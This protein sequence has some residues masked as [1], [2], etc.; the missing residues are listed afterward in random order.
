[1]VTVV[2]IP[3]LPASYLGVSLMPYRARVLAILI[4][5]IC[6]SHGGQLQA[7]YF[8]D[9]VV[10]SLEFMTATADLVVRARIK[11]STHEG[12]PSYI[13]GRATIE[14]S[15]VIKGNL[16]KPLVVPIVMHR[17]EVTDRAATGQE[18]LFFLVRPQYVRAYPDGKLVEWEFRRGYAALPVFRPKC[19]FAVTM[20]M[21]VLTDFE[22]IREAVR[23]EALADHDLVTD[24]PSGAGIHGGLRDEPPPKGAAVL[25]V[26]RHTA[27]GQ[28]LNALGARR[29]VVP[30]DARAERLA[31]GWARDPRMAGHVAEVLP[32][33]RSAENATILRGLLDHPSSGTSSA[34]GDDIGWWYGIRGRSYHTLRRWGGHVRPPRLN[35]PEDFLWRPTWRLWGGLAAVA[36]AGHFLPRRRQ[37]QPLCARL[38]QGFKF[39]V[40]LSLALVSGTALL[41]W[42]GTGKVV[43]EATSGSGGSRYR[44]FN[45]E[46]SLVFVRVSDRPDLVR[47]HEPLRVGRFVPSECPDVWRQTFVRPERQFAF[48]GFDYVRGRTPYG[49]GGRGYGYSRAQVSL[50]GIVILT[51]IVPAA[52]A[53]H[54]LRAYVLRRQ[55][56]NAGR[57]AGCGYDPRGGNDRC[58]ECGAWSNSREV[59]KRSTA[60]LTGAPAPA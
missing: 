9:G 24:G 41:A 20:D 29:V 49:F 26:P 22:A 33:F 32:H 17:K 19:P 40:L 44:L 30:L 57:C 10:D 59:I 53:A 21:R 47:S 12:D 7:Q 52:W 55:W 56:R 34:Y 28:L 46:G 35:G 6:V 31:K 45:Y 54:R 3:L 51:G 27:Q 1:V 2:A 25:S 14:V 15:E 18:S 48:T 16:T 50:A 13:R 36:V 39:A 8:E 38:K 60:R 58:P 43:Y 11:V 23:A 5:S 42:A 4:A 37:P